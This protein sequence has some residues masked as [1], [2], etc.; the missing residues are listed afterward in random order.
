MCASL[1]THPGYDS[2]HPQTVG[3]HLKFCGNVSELSAQ[4]PE[5]SLRESPTGSSCSA[6]TRILAGC[7]ALPSRMRGSLR[8]FVAQGVADSP[9]D[10][11]LR[12]DRLFQANNAS[13]AR[14]RRFTSR[15]GA[16]NDQQACCRGS[17]FTFRGNR[18]AA[19]WFLGGILAWGDCP[20]RFRR[21]SVSARCSDVRGEKR[22]L[23][24]R[25]WIPARRPDRAG[26]RRSAI[27]SLHLLANSSD[28]VSAGA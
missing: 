4:I 9:S 22:W 23:E 24:I 5:R 20:D 16:T 25:S 11:P 3:L 2:P 27:L 13:C 26:R 15:S 1:G 14:T 17:E 12:A 28:H 8:G 21:Q 10:V 19:C 6:S 7:A 18:C